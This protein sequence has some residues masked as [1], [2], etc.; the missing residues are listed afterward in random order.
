MTRQIDTATLDGAAGYYASLYMRDAGPFDRA[1]VMKQ[2]HNFDFKDEFEYL[3]D[4]VS[5]NLGSVPATDFGMRLDKLIKDRPRDDALFHGLLRERLAIGPDGDHLDGAIGLVQMGSRLIGLHDIEVETPESLRRRRALGLPKSQRRTH[6]KRVPHYWPIYAGEGEERAAGS[7]APDVLPDGTPPLPVGAQ[8]MNVSAEIA[9]L[10]LDALLDGLDEGTSNATI[11]GRSGAQPADP[12][13]AV[14][15]TLGFS[16]AMSD[17]AFAGASDQADGTVQAAASAISDDSSADA[18]ITL[19]YNRVS[20]T[21]DGITPIDDHID[22]EAGTSGA[23]FNFNT[24]SIV[25]GATISMSAYTI[26][27]SQGSTAS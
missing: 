12:D 23:D 21:N 26:T 11:Q 17:P 20:A 13:A 14:T 5:K 18:T 19:G 22:G 10:G 15:G 8:V 3:I 27:Q 7:K 6:L 25:S 1:W 4:A 24:L 9:I 16:L 2:F